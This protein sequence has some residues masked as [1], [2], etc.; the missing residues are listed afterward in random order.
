MTCCIGMRQHY[1]GTTLASYSQ[2]AKLGE[3]GILRS[4]T[5]CSGRRLYG[6]GEW[7]GE[8]TFLLAFLAGRTDD[9][10][11][12]TASRDSSQVD[13]QFDGHGLAVKLLQL[14]LH[15]HLQL[16]LRLNANLQCHES[17]N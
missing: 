17:R 16:C 7:L 1:C 5:T 11:E 2:K 8:L 3:D 4:W 9:Q 12:P 13:G 10:Q 6:A 14:H 15:P